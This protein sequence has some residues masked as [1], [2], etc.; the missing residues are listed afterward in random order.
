MKY[1]HNAIALVLLTGLVSC[2]TLPR[3]GAERVPPQQAP[4]GEQ[5]ITSSARES[6]SAWQQA[7]K[8]KVHFTGNWAGPVVRLQPVLT[9]VEFRKS[10][11]ET[12]SPQS[13]QVIQIHNGPGG[14]KKVVRT[15]QSISVKFNG[16]PADDP[17]Q[18]AAAALVV[19]AY[20]LFT[21]G[22]SWLF[23]RGS[24]FQ[25]IGQ[26]KL[27]G[28]SCWLV[29]AEVVPGFGLSERDWVIAWIGEQS[30]RT[31]RVQLTLNGLEST[32]GADVDVTF[33]DWQRGPQGTLWPTSYV[34]RVRR[35]FDILAHTWQMAKVEVD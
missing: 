11:V 19:D 24:N 14:T 20:Q 21:F 9:D 34:E 13:G 31:H 3:P 15:P 28:E 25:V 27:N 29:Q 12:Y 17:E 30:L 7:R 10:S 16:E 8:V 26:R 35:P 6:G 23:D 2:T 32:A 5:L 22:A 18:L 4:D 1:L 33:N